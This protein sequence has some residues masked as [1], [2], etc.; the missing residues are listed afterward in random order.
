MLLTEELMNTQ[1][2]DKVEE[3]KTLDYTKKSY[4]QEEYIQEEII[5]R[6]KTKQLLQ[7]I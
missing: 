3:Y 1:F 4:I 2:Y 5:Y 6:R 7:N